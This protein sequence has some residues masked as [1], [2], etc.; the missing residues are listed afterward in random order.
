MSEASPML[1]AG[2]GTYPEAGS[3]PVVLPFSRATLGAALNDPQNSIR[4]PRRNAPSKRGRR[5]VNSKGSRLSDRGLL[6]GHH[7]NRG[8]IMDTTTLPGTAPEATLLRSPDERRAA[9]KALRDVS[10]REDHGHWKA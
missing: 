9:G 1:N 8:S 2:V 10:P 5:P 3:P 4:Q 7:V 6:K